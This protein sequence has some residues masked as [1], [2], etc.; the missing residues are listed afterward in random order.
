MSLPDLLPPEDAIFIGGGDFQRIGEE[1]FGYLVG[2]GGLRPHDRVLDVGCGIGRLAIPLTRYLK[3]PGSYDGLDI[4]PLG[5]DWCR[6]QITPRHPRFRFHLADVFNRSYNPRGR[7]DAST[8]AFPFLP[9]SFD[10][11]FLTSVFTHM[12]PADLE[13]YLYEISRVL[14][15]GGKCLITYFL[16]NAESAALM[17][18]GRSQFPFKYRRG[19]YRTISRHRPED[20]VC[21]E[22]GF[23]RT[24]HQKYG[25]PIEGS[26]RYGSWCGRAD[27]LS[28]QDIV[29]AVRTG[30]PTAPKPRV[31]GMTR[32][33]LAVR[34][35]F[36][37]RL[38]DPLR[39]LSRHASEVR[40]H[41]QAR[42]TC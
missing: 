17:E 6:E 14:R 34:R 18:A 11:V 16:V 38:V 5:I 24:L 36:Y 40:R 39:R 41:V 2:L 32:L 22:E 33:G 25:L 37:G 31:P 9:A 27:F 3:A 10:F 23:I 1:F 30:A 42:Q 7:L 13:N 21:Y 35:M 19:G 8:Y 4:V 28:H 15:R 29:L 20:A 26:I 12:L